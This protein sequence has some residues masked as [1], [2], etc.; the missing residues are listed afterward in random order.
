MKLKLFIIMMTLGAWFQIFG[1]EKKDEIIYILK[2]LIPLGMV[3]GAPLLIT[4]VIVIVVK[5]IKY[6]GTV[7][8]DLLKKEPDKED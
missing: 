3:I 4:I 7:T 5:I 8:I 1:A 6:S 2:L